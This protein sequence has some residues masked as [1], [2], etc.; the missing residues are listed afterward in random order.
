MTVEIEGEEYAIVDIGMRMLTP[1]EQ[2]AAQGFPEDY[3]IDTGADGKPMPKTQQTHKCGNSVCPPIAAALVAAN[4]NHL[5]AEV[6]KDAARRAKL[7]T[8]R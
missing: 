3:V 7:R 6:K 5:K 1:R 2:F 4:C 8:L